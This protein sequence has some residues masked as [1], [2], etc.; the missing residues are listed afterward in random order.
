MGEDVKLD[1]TFPRVQGHQTLQN[2]GWPD[3]SHHPPDC[4]PKLCDMSTGSGENMWHPCLQEHI[5]Q[6][7]RGHEA[8]HKQSSVSRVAKAVLLHSSRLAHGRLVRVQAA[9][10]AAPRLNRSYALGLFSLSLSLPGVACFGG[11]FRNTGAYTRQ[12]Q[13]HLKLLINTAE[14]MIN[15]WQIWSQRGIPC[16][17]K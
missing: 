10:G 6:A 16:K 15:K 1:K 17:L 5:Y 4:C 12:L 14:F 7:Q 3:T 11:M 9:W 13:V 2:S 8:T